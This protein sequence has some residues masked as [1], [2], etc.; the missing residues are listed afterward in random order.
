MSDRKALGEQSEKVGGGMT[1]VGI[2]LGAEP[3]G[4]PAGPKEVWHD[5]FVGEPAKIITDPVDGMPRPDDD[6]PM[7]PAPAPL[8]PETL[9]CLEDDSEWVEVWREE[10]DSLTNAIGAYGKKHLRSQFSVEGIEQVRQ[11]FPPSTE[12]S[13][14]WGCPVVVSGSTITFVRPKRKRCQHLHAFVSPVTDVDVQGKPAEPIFMFCDRF[15]TVGGAKMSLFDET[16]T[17]CTERS[18]ADPSSLAKIKARIDSKIE[19]GKHRTSLPIFKKTDDGI[20][21]DDWAKRA[22]SFPKS[23]D[24]IYTP[25]D[26][27]ARAGIPSTQQSSLAIVSPSSAGDDVSRRVAIVVLVEESWQPPVDLY[28]GRTYGPYEKWGVEGRDERVLRINL[29]EPSFDD[30]SDAATWPAYR[31][32]L[33]PI[34]LMRNAKM[35]ASAL[36]FGK[37]VDVVATSSTAQAAFFAAL[38]FAH[39][40]RCKGLD[41]LEKLEAAA[42]KELATSLAFRVF[43]RGVDLTT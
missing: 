29:D 36:E 17:A 37:N 22:A 21:I 35:C 19:A 40:H 13:Y 38:V 1:E 18:P 11:T 30:E 16:V 34:A 33:L 28:E 9:V 25:R 31:Q 20:S 10:E 12:I 43:L 14:R 2:D 32:A 42:G 6:G 8:S 4:P 7:P 23:R 24:F 41:A 15:R 27:L 39:L 3:Q 5:T 26:V